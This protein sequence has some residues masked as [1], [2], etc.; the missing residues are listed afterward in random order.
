M[1][2][3]NWTVRTPKHLTVKPLDGGNFN[4][5]FYARWARELTDIAGY[6]ERAVPVRNGML[7]IVCKSEE[8]SVKYQQITT[9]AGVTVEVK[10]N[11]ILNKSKGVIREQL[12]ASATR[13]DIIQEFE[14]QGVI[15]AYRFKKRI[16]GELKDTQ[17]ILVTFNTP[18]P[19]EYLTSYWM[20]FDV[21]KYNE[22]PRKCFNCQMFGHGIKFCKRDYACPNCSEN[23]EK[24]EEKCERDPKCINCNES[25][26]TNEKSC[27]AKSFEE[28]LISIRSSLGWRRRE[29]EDTLIRKGLFP[30]AHNRLLK[31]RGDNRSKQ[32]RRTYAEALNIKES[33][34]IIKN[35]KEPNTQRRNYQRQEINEED[36]GDGDKQDHHSQDRNMYKLTHIENTDSQTE[37]E[38]DTHG[39]PMWRVESSQ[40][41]IDNQKTTSE[42]ETE[43]NK[44]SS[45]GKKQRKKKRKKTNSP[46]GVETRSKKAVKERVME[47]EGAMCGQRS[48]IL[49]RHSYL[50]KD[51]HK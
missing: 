17:S 8:Q 44:T 11:E 29:I 16:N 23:H 37:S 10:G 36:S 41:S 13:E 38:V 14:A 25:H 30:K 15:D 7:N 45:E 12:L 20:K 19:P 32:N 2:S 50:N 34:N 22:K 39:L 4:E 1:E 21:F 35:K 47:M 46:E 3:H 26:K 28:E 51:D 18:Q 48:E 33:T 9:L 43:L 24:T 40:S 5:I 27:E 42:E 31:E 6:P 49:E